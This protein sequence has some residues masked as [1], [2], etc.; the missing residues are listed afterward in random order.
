VVAAK[1]AELNFP[2][3]PVN[4]VYIATG[5]DFP[6]GLS[7]S[8]AAAR[9]GGPLLLVKG[10]TIPDAIRAQLVRLKPANIVVSGG[11]GVVPDSV[12]TELAKLTTTIRR[13]AGADRYETSRVV[14]RAAFTSA[15]T[16]Y[17][18]T[19]A[20]FP[21]AL[22]ASAAAAAVDAPVILVPGYADTV[23]APTLQLLRDFGVTSVTI[24]GGAGAVSAGI[25]AQLKGVLGADKVLRHGGA[26]RYAVTEA[27]NRA[28]FDRSATVYIAT[29]ANF[30]D[31]LAGAAVA[32]GQNAPLYVV[33]GTCFPKNVLQDIVDSGAT[34]VVLLGGAAVLSPNLEK[35]V[36]CP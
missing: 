31:A 2:T 26:D 8:A 36:N 30:P 10:A 24:A 22:S 18:A 3:A 25:E 4:T 13:D 34:K 15:T 32:G 16:A 11:P 1:L 28:A 7:A 5:A 29:G 19:G 17:I 27:I 35:W 20:D 12:Y 33:R 21:D 9:A 14:A 6:D 23:D